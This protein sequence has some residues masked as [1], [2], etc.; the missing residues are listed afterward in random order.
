MNLMQIT[1]GNALVDGHP[2]NSWFIGDLKKWVAAKTPDPPTSIFNLRQSQIVE[3]KWG[4]HRA[5]EVRTDWALCSDKRTISI[6]V[7]G[8]FL[9]RFR[10]PTD[11]EQIIDQRLER[12]GDYA[13]WGNDVE[14]TWLVEE[15]SVIL[16]VRW[17]DQP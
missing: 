2:F 8:K 13:V 9:L 17:R 1:L 6:L 14:H 15:D 16:T 11:R 10:S 5:G 3:M 12:E 7:R 4:E